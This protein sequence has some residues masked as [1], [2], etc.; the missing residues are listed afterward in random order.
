MAD[1][2]NKV[3]YQIYPICGSLRFL[4][5]PRGIT[6]MMWQITGGLTGNSEPWRT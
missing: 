5:L 6:V 2:S 3:I 4:S 1:F